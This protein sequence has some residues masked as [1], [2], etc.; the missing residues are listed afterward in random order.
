MTS[1]AKASYRGNTEGPPLPGGVANDTEYQFVKKSGALADVVVSTRAGPDRQRTLVR[2]TAVLTDV[3]DRKHSEERFAKA[4]ILAP[5]PMMLSRLDGGEVVDATQAFLTMITRTAAQVVGRQ[6]DQLDLGIDGSN[7]AG[8]GEAL[9]REGSLRNLDV[10]IH[11]VDGTMIDCLLS[12]ELVNL[13]GQCC[14]LIVLQDITDRRRSENQLF[15]ALETVMRDTSWFSR[16]VIEKLAHL[17]QPNHAAPQGPALD[18]LTKRE[19]EILSHLSQGDKDD[20]IA[21]VLGLSRSTVRNHIAAI[22]AKIG[23]HSR[24]S[25]IVWARERGLTGSI[26]VQKQ[27]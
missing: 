24:S 15:E 26:G 18:D 1:A 19:V 6:V 3:T 22:Y 23:V 10:T 27:R 5:V 4:F 20:E 2:T 11:A 13:Q 25:A 21:G 7:G 16:S 8:V 12:A 14:A 17:R 9:R